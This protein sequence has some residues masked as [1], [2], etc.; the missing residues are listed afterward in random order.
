MEEVFGGGKVGEDEG[1]LVRGGVDLGGVEGVEEAVGGGGEGG[2]VIEGSADEGG[3]VC[4]AF[5]A[6]KADVH[7]W[8]GGWVDGEGERGRGGE[9]V[10]L[11]VP[12]AFG[13]GI[14]AAVLDEGGEAV[15]VCAEPKVAGGKSGGFADGAEVEVF[16]LACGV[17][18][19]DDAGFFGVE[20]DADVVAAVFGD[21]A[22]FAVDF[23]AAADFGGDVVVVADVLAVRHGGG[24]RGW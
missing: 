24:G 7:G 12:G 6:G 5:G 16:D 18:V 19:V 21:D 15:S 14:P 20:V 22:G 11:L 17:G 4:N 1:E 8:V 2:D 3:E 10:R 9:G 13:V 23:D